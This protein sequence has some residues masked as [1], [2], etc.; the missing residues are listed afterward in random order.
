MDKTIEL[1]VY[2]TV[3]WRMRKECE[4]IGIWPEETEL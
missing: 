4:D 1:D 3:N 2:I